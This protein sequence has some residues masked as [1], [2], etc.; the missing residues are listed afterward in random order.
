M[1]DLTDIAA[2]REAMRTCRRC[3]AFRTLVNNAGKDDRLPAAEIEPDYW[4]DR[5]GR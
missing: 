5:F 1:C 4:D 2:T 3:G